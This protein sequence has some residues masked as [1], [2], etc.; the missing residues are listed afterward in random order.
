MSKIKY[1]GHASLE[2]ITN[3]KLVIYIDPYVGEYKDEADIILV[4]HEHMDHNQ[5][6]LVPRK[7]N[8]III[9]QNNLK[10]GYMYHKTSIDGVE[11]EAVEAYNSKHNKN[12]CVGYILRFDGKNI[13]V[14]GDTSTTNHMKNLLPNYNIDYAFLPVDGIYNMDATEA[15]ECANIFKPKYAIPYHTNPKELF[16]IEIANQFKYDNR[17]IL[18]INEEI[19]F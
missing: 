12:T 3:E 13:Y 10:V 1:L 18:N 5:I 17:I 2:L 16:D 6:N 14:A 11:I 8:T 19:E 15:S 9:R 4:T 7:D